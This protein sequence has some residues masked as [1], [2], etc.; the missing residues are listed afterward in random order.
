MMLETEKEKQQIMLLMMMMVIKAIWTL[1]SWLSQRVKVKAKVME[2]KVETLTARQM[3]KLYRQVPQLALMHFLV[4]MNLPSHP[5][6]MMMNPMLERQPAATAAAATT[7]RANP[8]PQNMQ[9]AM[10]TRTK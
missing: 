3:H 9:W 7:E 8:A 1:I 6:Q 5:I 10:R 4:M 2:L